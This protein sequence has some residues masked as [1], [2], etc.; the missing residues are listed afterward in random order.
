MTVQYLEPI[1]ETDTS[2]TDNG[3]TDEMGLLLHPPLRANIPPSF[4]PPLVH[5]DTGTVGGFGWN[6]YP[7][8]E[9]LNAWQLTGFVKPFYD[10]NDPMGPKHIAFLDPGVDGSGFSSVQVANVP[11]GPLEKQVEKVDFFLG[12]REVGIK[13]APLKFYF[14]SKQWT[15]YPPG[16]GIWRWPVKLITPVVEISEISF[17]QWKPP[18]NLQPRFERVPVTTRENF[19]AVPDPLLNNDYTWKYVDGVTK[20]A[21][22]KDHDGRIYVH[23]DSGPDES[24]IVFYNENATSTNSNAAFF[25]EIVVDYLIPGGSIQIEENDGT[26]I[27]EITKAGR[28]K[29]K[30]TLPSPRIMTGKKP[31]HFSPS[32]QGEGWGTEHV[33]SYFY[34]APDRAF[35]CVNPQ[36]FTLDFFWVCDG[37]YTDLILNQTYLPASRVG[38]T[39][40]TP[41]G[42]VALPGQQILFGETPPITGF[43]HVGDICYNTSPTGD[44]WAWRCIDYGNP[45]LWEPVPAPAPVV[46]PGP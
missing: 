36:N 43:Y 35:P 3:T 14:G 15:I 39:V 46:P 16:P 31:P 7:R 42:L 27:L 22:R 41:N 20:T 40:K 10:T 37:D 8:F 25:W 9:N 5:P 33:I 11:F 32:F 23:W 26:L 28:Y 21:F 24:G 6:L 30:S 12:F 45:G 4:M 17:A 29:G 18:N 44:N 34:N 19:P 38:Q 1:L 2:V 13:K